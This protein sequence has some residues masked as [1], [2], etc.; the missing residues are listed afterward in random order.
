ML[1]FICMIIIIASI[2]FSLNVCAQDND[3][4]FYDLTGITIDDISKIEIKNGTTGESTETS[5][6]GII[7]NIVTFLNNNSLR[8][9]KASENSG[10]WSY[11][12][13]IHLKSNDKVYNYTVPY[14]IKIDGKKYFMNDAV[15]FRNI[16]YIYF[17]KITEKLNDEE[18][19]N[20]LEDQ[21]ILRGDSNGD[22]RLDA[23]ITRAEAIAVI[24]RLLD[25]N[26][27]IDKYVFSDVGEQFWANKYI[28]SAYDAGLVCGYDD[29]T[30]RP[31]N[32]VLYEE[33]IKLIVLSLGYG[34]DIKEQDAYPT[35]YINIAE[36]LGLYNKSYD[37]IYLNRKQVTD[38]V[39]QAI[40]IPIKEKNA[41]NSNLFKGNIL[42]YEGIFTIRDHFNKG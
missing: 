22:L 15:G 29:N 3:V 4:S 28:V 5:D 27:V 9:N 35:G 38:I 21:G 26:G 14:G 6:N 39:W 7:S 42:N 19:I 10:G 12:L 31:Y 11:S 16:L 8:E 18:K 34:S 13:S 1:K 2:V 23:E 41:A 17:N 30:F 32:K 24:C 36:K 20:L 37:N 40:N 25:L 33:F